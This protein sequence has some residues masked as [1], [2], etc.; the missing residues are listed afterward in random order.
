M[1]MTILGGDLDFSEWFRGLVA[2]FI[3]GGASAVSGGI[4]VSA[5]DSKDYNFQTGLP[6]LLT[7]M[8]VMFLVNGILSM[9]LFLRQSPVPSHKTVMTTEKTTVVQPTSPPTKIETT[10]VETHKEPLEP[11]T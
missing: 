2:S 8:G 6:K 4:T 3:S 1:P 5:L 7:L 11:K 10:V 9:M